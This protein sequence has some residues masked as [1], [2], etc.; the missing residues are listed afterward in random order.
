MLAAIFIVVSASMRVP[1]ADASASNDNVFYFSDDTVP[2]TYM[3][4][5]TFT[6]GSEVSAT[7]TVVDF[8][9][10]TFS[11]TETQWVEAGVSEVCIVTS[12]TGGGQSITVELYGGTTLLGSGTITPGGA[13][14]QVCSGTFST[15]GYTFAAG[16]TLHVVLTPTAK[17][18]MW[19]GLTNEGTLTTATIV[20]ENLVLFIAG[21]GALLLLA[22]LFRWKKQSRS[23]RQHG[24]RLRAQPG[25]RRLAAKAR[26]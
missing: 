8:Y 10:D 26:A 21:G 12:K 14:N 13:K 15:N 24:G 3:M 17:V 2:S 5:Q 25:A 19:W 6:A 20:P 9:S 18:T 7:G 1:V 22:G 11:D 23:R 16:E 4:W